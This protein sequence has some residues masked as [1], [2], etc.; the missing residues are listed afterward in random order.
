M[1]YKFAISF[2]LTHWKEGVHLLLRTKRFGVNNN[3]WSD[4]DSLFGIPK[5]KIF[6][7]IITIKPIIENYKMMKF[8]SAGCHFLSDDTNK[9]LG[10]YQ[11]WKK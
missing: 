3:W 7:S 1:D 2:C 5:T 10:W 11:Y 4:F 8:R 9:K 6:I